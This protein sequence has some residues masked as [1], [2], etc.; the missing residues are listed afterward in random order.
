MKKWLAAV[1]LALGVVSTPARAGIPVIDSSNLV[2][3]I[4]EVMNSLQQIQNQIN[5]IQQLDNQIQQLDQNLQSINGIRGLLNVANNPLLRDYI[6]TAA[7]QILNAI[8]TNGYAGLQGAAKAARDADM[9]YNCLDLGGAQQQQCQARL[10]MPFQ[11]RQFYVDAMD[12]SV[13]R[14][15]Q[16]E[17]LRNSAA[18]AAD[19]KA[20]QEAQAR[21]QVEQAMLQ[22]EL[23]QI[24][25]MS[26]RARAEEAVVATRSIERQA[27]EATKPTRVT[28]LPW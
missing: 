25:L 2:Q 18:G 12:R 22:H 3:A 13:Q 9:V 27:A 4:Q 1:L 17:Q 28:A 11:Q 6:P 23:A 7:P 19:P 14:M 24:E 21:I 8:S 16:I 20:I 26:N 10:A 15:N 5:Q